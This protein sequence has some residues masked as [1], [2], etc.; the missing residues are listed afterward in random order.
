MQ[1]QV[2]IVFMQIMCFYYVNCKEDVT[3]FPHSASVEAGGTFN[4]TCEYTT[5]FYGLQFYKQGTG[6][7]LQHLTILRKDEV[8]KEDRFVFRLQKEKQLSTV[9]IKQVE[10]SD[11]AIY[12]CALQAQC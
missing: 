9:S 6:E 5:T 10:V 12:W 7:K 8:V 3:Q 1:N 11:S 4:M 2:A